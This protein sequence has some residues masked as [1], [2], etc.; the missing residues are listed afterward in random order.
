MSV[1]ILVVDDERSI[2]QLLK[3]CLEYFDCTVD[4][5]SNGKEAIAKLAETTYR[6]VFL[7][8]KM[9]GGMDGLAVL[10]WIRRREPALPVVIMSGH[11]AS[12]VVLPALTAGAQ[13]CLL[14]PFD[15]SQ[16]KRI[17]QAWGG[18]A[19]TAA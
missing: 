18:S 6:G 9:P 7:D 11:P 3:A 8:F 10:R 16:L 15:I 13:A 19:Y 4:T 17:V 12:E 5:A 2:Q 1:R 14:K